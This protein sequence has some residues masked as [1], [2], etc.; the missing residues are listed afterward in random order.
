MDGTASI[1]IESMIACNVAR[2]ACRE[3]RRGRARRDAGEEG[4]SA[5]VDVEG[6]D[7]VHLGLTHIAVI[8]VGRGPEPEALAAGVDVGRWMLRTYR[9]LV[10]SGQRRRRGLPEPAM[11]P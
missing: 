8:A 10:R 7:P 3:V 6:I 4:E 1:L 2:F 5:A 11:R 9:S